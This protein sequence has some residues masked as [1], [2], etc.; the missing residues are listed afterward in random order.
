M[1][2]MSNQPFP[3]LEA[4]GAHTFCEARIRFSCGENRSTNSRE[5]TGLNQVL[6][7]VFSWTVLAVLFGL[8]TL[9]SAQQTKL[10]IKLLP[11][12]PGTVVVE[13]TCAPATIWSFRDSY[14]GVLNLGGRIK[15]FRLFD[16]KG[17][18][19]ATRQLAPGQF[20]S[21]TPATRFRYEVDLRPPQRSAD[22]SRVSWLTSE[23]GLLMLRDL[24]PARGEPA[25]GPERANLRLSLPPGWLAHINE[26]E[27]VRGE[28]EIADADLAVL[29]VGRGL[30]VST[31]TSS[32][33]TLTLVLAG[34]W[35]FN[36]AE[37]LELATKVLKTDRDMFGA[38]PS[39]RAT[40]ILFPFPQS[41]SST[42]NWTAET[43]GFSVTLLTGKLPSKVA[44][45]AQ[46]SSPLTHEF[47]HFWVPNG[48]NLTGDYDWFY[49]GFTVYQAAQM[50][51]RMGLLTFQE[52]LNAISRAYDGYFLSLDRDRWSLLEASKMRWTTGNYA[53]Y[54]KSML[55]AFLYDLNLRSL[56]HNKRSLDDV[57]RSIF[58]EYGSEPARAG[59]GSDGSEAALKILGEYSG[60]QEFG[61]SL[62]A[63][64]AAINLAEKL[65]P[66]GLRVETLGL[67]TRIDVSDS[68]TRQQ[69]DLLHDLGY[70]DY[71]R[72]PRQKKPS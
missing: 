4:F 57:Y 65:A 71:V 44:A 69:R 42:D 62:I 2:S 7:R 18:E 53:V 66:F 5:T 37:A 17:A 34:D 20:R 40:L 27:N 59:Q 1:K 29:A 9:A 50:A 43:R 32:G 63:N 14:A 70:N 56:S 25:Q 22:A 3:S 41:S 12:A 19:V 24:L 8:S 49:E 28:F 23:R 30:R 10:E 60:L 68:L 47:L 39:R 55:V 33:L 58:R 13:G 21:E 46:L 26:S 38:W 52:F 11:E 45:L 51:V 6:L 54:A 36:D 61:R 35:A 64:P 72:S 31:A 48:L 16:E 15:G 67:R